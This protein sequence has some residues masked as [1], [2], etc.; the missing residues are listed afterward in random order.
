MSAEGLRDC[1]FYLSQIPAVGAVLNP[2]SLPL[3][4][5]GTR[6][7]KGKSRS[8]GPAMSG[9]ASAKGKNPMR[10]ISKTYCSYELSL[11]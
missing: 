11:K 6:A 1:H 3:P 9:M 7:A 2:M 4:R 5:Y 10:R 8:S